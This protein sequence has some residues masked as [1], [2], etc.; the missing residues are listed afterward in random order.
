M[1]LVQLGKDAA[2]HPSD[3]MARAAEGMSILILFGKLFQGILACLWPDGSPY[4]FGDHSLHA[5]GSRGKKKGP[6]LLSH[7]THSNAAPEWKRSQ[8]FCLCQLFALDVGSSC[9]E[10][11]WR[12]SLLPACG[13]LAYPTL[14]SH[15]PDSEVCKVP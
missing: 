14:I 3:C 11:S 6:E 7:N 8:L 13:G 5:L 4:S 1:I 12:A 9:A 2:L 15:R 10:W